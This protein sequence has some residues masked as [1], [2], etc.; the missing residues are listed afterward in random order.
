MCELRLGYSS[1]AR[2]HSRC[3]MVCVTAMPAGHTQKL[4]LGF[5]V[6]L[7]DMPTH[8]TFSA[9]VAWIDGYDRDASQL[10]LVFDKAS[11]LGETPIVQA[12][13]LLFVGLTAGSNVF[14]ILDLNA[15][16]GAFRSGNDAL[17]N[18]MV[19]VLLE[20]PL[21]SA[22]LPEAAFRGFC[23]DTLKDSATFSVSLPVR[24]DAG[25]GMLVPETIGCDINDAEIHSQ[26]AVGG[27][28]AGVVE[29]T[30]RA[31]IPLSAHEH[32]INFAFAMLKQLS[33]MLSTNVSDLFAPRQQP[34]RNKFIRAKAQNSVVVGL[35]CMLAEDALRFLVD[36][37][38]IGNLCY[39]THSYL[40]SQLELCAKFSVKR[41]VHIKLP[42]YLRF[43]SSRREP[44]A[45]FV[46]T[47]KGCAEQSF[48][49]FAGF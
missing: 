48:L 29:I 17:G 5:P 38:R 11:K 26:H 37:V 43:P 33:L 10:C 15:E 24:F 20:S 27:E 30:N 41:F 28:Q 16:S 1:P 23:A 25:A 8:E 49:A 4:G 7:I 34:K 31:Q 21:F 18:A 35:S 32:Q 22:Y 42:K 12:F 3:V 45:S 40:C 13:S 14:Q 46:A 19:M 47:L 39:A 36:L 44:I 9:R 2:N 6:A